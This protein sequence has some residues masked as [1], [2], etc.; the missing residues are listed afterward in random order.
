[1]LWTGSK[2][3]WPRSN[4]C[5][6]GILEFGFSLIIYYFGIDRGIPVEFHELAI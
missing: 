6:R 5:G 2:P 4:L 3:D 1:M